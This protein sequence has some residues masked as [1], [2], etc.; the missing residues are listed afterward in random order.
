MV[1][2][3]KENKTGNLITVSKSKNLRGIL[4]YARDKSEVDKVSLIRAKSAGCSLIRAKSAGCLFIVYKDDT[5]S[6]VDFKSYSVMK[7][8]VLKRKC[9]KDV[10]IEYI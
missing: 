5:W 2:I 8:W 1:K 9:F 10:K 6:V 7:Q 4:D 3:F